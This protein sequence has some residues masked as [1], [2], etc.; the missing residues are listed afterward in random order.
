MLSHCGQNTVSRPQNRI[1]SIVIAFGDHYFVLFYVMVKMMSSYCKPPS[2]SR[3]QIHFARC[4]T[5]SVATIWHTH[6]HVSMGIR[7][8]LHDRKVDCIRRR[9]HQRQKQNIIFFSALVGTQKIPVRFRLGCAVVVGSKRL[10]NAD[11]TKMA[12]EM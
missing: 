1:S 9:L 3:R 7:A 5:H 11:E 10:L 4:K 8:W 2:A 6:R 12:I